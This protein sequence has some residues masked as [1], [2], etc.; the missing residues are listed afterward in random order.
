MKVQFRIKEI[1]ESGDYFYTVEKKNLFSWRNVLKGNRYKKFFKSEE[2][3]EEWIYNYV[4]E[5]NLN[6]D[7]VVIQNLC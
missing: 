1:E 6:P 2:E 7:E 4:C 3:C 5:N